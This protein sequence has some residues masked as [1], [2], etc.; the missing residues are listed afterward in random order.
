MVKASDLIRTSLN[1]RRDFPTNHNSFLV[2]HKIQIHIYKFMNAHE[3]LSTVRNN[4]VFQ[5]HRNDDHQA[6]KHD[7]KCSP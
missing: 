1:P 5:K 3:G 2:F 7:A 4:S 6:G